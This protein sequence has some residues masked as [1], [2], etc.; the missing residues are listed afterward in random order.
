MKS[1]PE[2]KQH[3]NIEQVFGNFKVIRSKNIKTQIDKAIRL[4]S[5]L[6]QEL[7]SITL[8]LPE[9]GRL[10]CEILQK[11]VEKSS[12]S[13]DCKIKKIGGEVTNTQFKRRSS[14]LIGGAFF[15]T[16]EYPQN[17][18]WMPVIQL[19]LR[20]ISVLVNRNLGDG[21]LQLWYVQGAD[22]L[23]AEREKIIVL[24]RS[25]VTEKLLNPWRHLSYDEAEPTDIDPLN[26]DWNGLYWWYIWDEIVGVVSKGIQCQNKLIDKLT[27]ELQAFLTADLITKILL[28]SNLCSF[29]DPADFYTVSIFGSFEPLTYSNAEIDAE[30]LVAFYLWGDEF[31]TPGNAQLYLTTDSANN[32]LFTFKESWFGNLKEQEMERIIVTKNRENPKY[33]KQKKLDH[34]NFIDHARK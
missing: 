33:L 9:A 18:G 16:E 17:L 5:E 7:K 22:I 8:K 2:I 19:D 27:L 30:C 34:E 11:L 32:I 10:T 20:N 31:K 13:F 24:P 28:F 29:K 3:S 12:E 23:D 15:T 6:T 21:L 1:N 26:S 25:Q 4:R 14:S